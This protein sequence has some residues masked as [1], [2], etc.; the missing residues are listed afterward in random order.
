MAV[1]WFEA[2]IVIDLRELYYPEG[3]RFP[4]I[5]IPTWMG[6]VELAREAASLLLLA[7]GARLAGEYFLERFSA[8]MVLFGVWDLTYYAGLKLVLDWPPT[9]GTWDLLFLLPVPWVGPVWAP[10][11]VSVALV[12]VG[13]Y[14]YWTSDVRRRYRWRDWMVASAGGLVVIGSFVAD[15]RAV[16]DE[17]VPAAYPAWVFWVGFSMAVGWFVHAERRARAVA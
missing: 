4:V 11:V 12:S 16:V 8:F 7:A 13:T 2:A 10:S 3:F 17:R 9:W 6:A 1:G 15:W 5:I 14:L